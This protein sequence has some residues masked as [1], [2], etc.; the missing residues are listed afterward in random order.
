MRRTSYCLAVASVLFVAL[1]LICHGLFS[2]AEW[3]PLGREKTPRTVTY[4]TLHQRQI[5]IVK[6]RE[7][8]NRYPRNIEEVKSYL[9]KHSSKGQEPV[10]CVDGWGNDLRYVHVWSPQGAE[11]FD[12]YSVGPNGIDEADRADH[13]DDIHI[14]PD[15]QIKSAVTQ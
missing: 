14:A 8:R 3:W 12:L 13:G 2:G 9:G 15:G 4:T 1:L 11:T 7:H 6:F 10:S 5:D